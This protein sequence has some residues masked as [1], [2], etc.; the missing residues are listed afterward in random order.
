MRPFPVTADQLDRYQRRARARVFWGHRVSGIVDSLV[1]KGVKRKDAD[2][3]VGSAVAEYSGQL[4]VG[5][6]A[7]AAMAGVSLMIAL[8]FHSPQLLQGQPMGPVD[9]GSLGVIVLPFA[10][11]GV[12]LAGLALTRFLR[13]LLRWV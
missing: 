6:L 5:G 1:R 4:A 2:Q 13:S 10:C 12:A 8:L 7:Y 3:M 11:V 9:L